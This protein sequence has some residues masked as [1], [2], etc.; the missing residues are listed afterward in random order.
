MNPYS[1]GKDCVYATLDTE[2]EYNLGS[3]QDVVGLSV[4]VNYPGRKFI[5]CSICICTTSHVNAGF[6]FVDHD[7]KPF[8]PMR[9]KT[10]NRE[11]VHFSFEPP[12]NSVENLSVVTFHMVAE[13]KKKVQLQVRADD[14]GKLRVNGFASKRNVSYNHMTISTLTVISL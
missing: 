8:S 1:P 10:N 7:G 14:A 9:T 13:V 3:W 4:D 6:Q 5:I 12:A 11:P 2:A